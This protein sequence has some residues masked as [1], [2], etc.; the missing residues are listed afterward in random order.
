MYVQYARRTAV[1]FRKG[2]LKL[3]RR[4]VNSIS[5]NNS[6]NSNNNNHNNNRNNNRSNNNSKRRN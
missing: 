4:R 5:N 1:K 6:N 3:G 2:G